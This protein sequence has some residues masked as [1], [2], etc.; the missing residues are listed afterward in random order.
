MFET[1]TERE[2]DP[3]I[4]AYKKDIDRTLIRENLRLTVEQ[5][6]EK[7]MR[8]QALAEELRKAGREQEIA[9]LTDAALKSIDSQPANAHHQPR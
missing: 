7:L 3:V 5:R 8:L 2:P 1:E 4:E 6:F 9:S